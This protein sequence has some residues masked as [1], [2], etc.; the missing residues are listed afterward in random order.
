MELNLETVEVYSFVKT[1]LILQ[2][3]TLA[4]ALPAGHLLVGYSNCDWCSSWVFILQWRVLS[5]KNAVAT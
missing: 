4:S 3:S 2:I 5:D 1:S